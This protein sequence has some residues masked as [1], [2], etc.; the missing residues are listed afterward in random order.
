MCHIKCVSFIF[1]HIKKSG[2][3]GFPPG[4]RET[5]MCSHRRWLDFLDVERSGIL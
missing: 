5:V 2:L 4:Q 1:I 3:V